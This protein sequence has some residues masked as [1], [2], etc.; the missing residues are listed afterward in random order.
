M[1]NEV[2]LPMAKSEKIYKYVGPEHFEK[3]FQA[4]DLATLKCS[5]PKEF[6]DPYELFLTIDFNEDPDALAFYADVIGDLP[7]YPTT[8]FSKSPIVLPMWAHYAQNLQGFVLE[9]SEAALLKVFPD[10]R[11]DDVGYSDTPSD[12][13]S[14]LL[15]RAYVIGKPRYT[16]F[17]QRG[18]LDAAYFT[19]ATCWSYEQERRMIVPPSDTR[20]AESQILLDVP[21][22][23][24]T[25]IICGPRASEET[26]LALKAKA[27]E[28]DCS[29]FEL[30]IGKSSAIPYLVNSD[31]EPFSFGPTGIVTSPHYCESCMEPLASATEQCS[32]CQIDD[33]LRHQVALRNPFR[34]LARAGLLESYIEGA[35]AIGQKRRDDG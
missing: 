34:I 13:L 4:P 16:Y 5:L 31:G 25:S 35:D 8:C 3:V 33:E 10:S 24:I 22:D 17:L 18:V 21:A 32:W 11:F 30:R 20:Q 9:V 19:K 29:Y 27:E 7:Q 12:G 23:C 28:L 14:E 15:Q 2:E 26:K 1:S 6:N